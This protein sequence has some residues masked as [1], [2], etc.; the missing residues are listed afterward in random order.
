MRLLTQYNHR[1]IR[2]SQLFK[3]FNNYQKTRLF[4]TY[5]SWNSKT[6][7][8]NVK[9]SIRHSISMTKPQRNDTF[10]FDKLALC[11][12]SLNNRSSLLIQSG[13]IFL[14]FDK[15]LLLADVGMWC[16]SCHMK[17]DAS[18]QNVNKLCDF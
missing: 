2:G 10:Q 6:S 13:A 12:W 17:G 18:T 4:D 11:D 15:A 3:N 5:Y 1:M 14:L 9:H 8:R 16:K 7:F